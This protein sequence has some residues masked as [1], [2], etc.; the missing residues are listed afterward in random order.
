MQNKSL[1][2]SDPTEDAVI[3]K[4]KKVARKKG[5]KKQVLPKFLEKDELKFSSI[6]PIDTN[7]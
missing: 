5:E 3:P 2:D 4:D 1:I 6:V 7:Y